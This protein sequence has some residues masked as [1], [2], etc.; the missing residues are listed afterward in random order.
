MIAKL[1]VHGRDRAEALEIGRRAL[2]EFHVG[3]VHSTIPFHQ[4]MLQDNAFKTGDYDLGYI[5]RLAAEGCQ[6]Q[7]EE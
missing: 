6:F 2:S 5:D 3:G 7:L 4:Y 1:I